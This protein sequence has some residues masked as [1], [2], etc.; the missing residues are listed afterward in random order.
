MLICAQHLFDSSLR[1]RCA[2]RCFREMAPPKE[3]PADPALRLSTEG[4]DRVVV[5][6]GEAR[7]VLAKGS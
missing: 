5:D 2:W 7:Y 6:T 3:A 1:S 4:A